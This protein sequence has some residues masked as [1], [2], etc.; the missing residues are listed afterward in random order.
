[1]RGHR[2][3][4]LYL[5]VSIILLILSFSLT[6]IP[7]LFKSTAM[8]VTTD[9]TAITTSSIS[10]ATAPPTQRKIVQ[11]SD[12]TI[13]AFVASGSYAMTCQQ[14]APAGSKYG[15]LWVKSS[16][17][18]TT[19]SCEGQIRMGASANPVASAVVD[20]NDNIY[21]VYPSNITVATNDINFVFYR[22]LTNS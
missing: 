5:Q 20:S 17:D 7:F 10:A 21:V 1:M 13:H 15:L 19:W 9:P 22:K 6:N 2:K 3:A 16:D 8:A 18:G 14:P 12:G 4:G 11:T